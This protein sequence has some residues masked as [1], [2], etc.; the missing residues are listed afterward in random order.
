MTSSDDLAE[1]LDADA[2]Q[3]LRDGDKPRLAV[4]RR[5]RA[6][7]KNAEI[8]ARTGGAAPDPVRILQ[9]LAKRHRESIEQFSAGGR[10]DLVD[11]ETAELAILEEYLPARATDAEIE[12]VVREIVAEAG[13][14]DAK[15]LGKIMK[16]ALDR[17][18]SGADGGRVREI[19]QRVLA[20]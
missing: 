10:Q 11:H 15:Q 12:A 4:L 20:G 7:L 2:K 9:G 5:A 6:A 3:A 18:G 14:T 13:I 19:A 8:E 1:R 16:P 17:L